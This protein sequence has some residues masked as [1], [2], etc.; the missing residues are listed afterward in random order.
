[1]HYAGLFDQP[2]RAANVREVIEKLETLCGS[3]SLTGYEGPGSEV[4]EE[5][6]MLG[7][8]W[9]LLYSTGFDRGNLGGQRPGPLIG[10]VAVTPFTVGQ[11]YQRIDVTTVSCSVGGGSGYMLDSEVFTVLSLS[12]RSL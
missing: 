5:M 3:V 9:R 2:R 11:I 12:L 8:V 4:S 1:M 10:Q 7:G 6:D